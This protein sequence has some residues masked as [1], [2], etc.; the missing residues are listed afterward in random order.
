MYIIKWCVGEACVFCHSRWEWAALA[1]LLDGCAEV[2]KTQMQLISFPSAFWLADTVWAIALY[3][4]HFITAICLT[5][6]WIGWSLW[7]F[8]IITWNNA[9][10]LH[11]RLIFP[12]LLLNFLQWV[13]T[14]VFC[15]WNSQKFPFGSVLLLYSFCMLRWLC[16]LA[17]LCQG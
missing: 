2:I 4:E 1:F 12:P 15:S 3:S 8:A 11:K 16:L 13:G 10:V 5:F 7:N 6:A 14:G 17:W 9:N